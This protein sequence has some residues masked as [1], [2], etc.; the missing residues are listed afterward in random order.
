MRKA[1]TRISAFYGANPL[2]L[3]GLLACFAL[4]GYAV[5]RTAGDPLLP[6]MLIWFGAAVVAHDLVLFPLYALADRS[7]TTLL[8][9]RRRMRDR[10][11][12]RV[13]PLNY[14]R[15]PALGSGLMLLLF[16]PGI[17]EQGRSSYAAATGQTQQPYLGR[18]LLL[19]AALFAISA[20][21]YTLRLCHARRALSACP[22]LISKTKRPLSA[23][24]AKVWQPKRHAK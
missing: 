23:V 22:S 9:P 8:R 5:L 11:A 12:P 21:V 24:R 10:G 15:V 1:L 7:V 6:R 19:T 18:W 16:L 4:A 13:P 3:L 2:H 20:V 14:V 17:I